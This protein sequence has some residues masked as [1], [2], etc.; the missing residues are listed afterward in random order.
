MAFIQI[1]PHTIIN[2]DQITQIRYLKREKKSYEYREG[3]DGK[4]QKIQSS[5]KI[6]SDSHLIIHF[7]SFDDKTPDFVAWKDEADILHD[8]LLEHIQVLPG[9]VVPL[10][11]GD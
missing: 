1:R 9:P 2:T 3:Y 4:K 5:A 6:V 8:F 10:D 11:S 7:T